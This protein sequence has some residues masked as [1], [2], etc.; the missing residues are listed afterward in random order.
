MPPTSRL[1]PRRK[2]MRLG[3]RFEDMWCDSSP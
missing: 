2:C 3:R 1:R